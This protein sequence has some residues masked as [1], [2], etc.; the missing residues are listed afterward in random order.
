M[1][2][3]CMCLHTSTKGC[4]NTYRCLSISLFLGLF[5]FNSGCEVIFCFC[6]VFALLDKKKIIVI[7]SH[8]F[9]AMYS[10]DSFLIKISS[11]IG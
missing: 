6:F 11:E 3:L 2:T 1:G 5:L 7:M 9:I 4:I 8:I 10:Y